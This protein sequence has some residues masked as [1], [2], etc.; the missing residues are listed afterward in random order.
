MDNKLY[1]TLT[2]RD[3]LPCHTSIFFL[4]SVLA[5]MTLQNNICSILW[6]VCDFG[7]WINGERRKGGALSFWFLSFKRLEYEG[8][9][10]VK[11]LLYRWVKHCS[12]R[13]KYTRK[14]HV[15]VP[16]VQSSSRKISIPGRMKVLGELKGSKGENKD[17]WS[18]FRHFQFFSTVFNSMASINESVCVAY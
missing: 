3:N 4:F 1:Y 7:K 15:V 17:L 11:K 16:V 13:F 10:K 8:K 9:R 18:Q 6:L 5:F 12:T 2:R 14:Q